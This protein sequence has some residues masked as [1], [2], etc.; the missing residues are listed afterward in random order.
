MRFWVGLIGIAAFFSAGMLHAAPSCLAYRLSELQLL[1][2]LGQGN[3]AEAHLA[4]LVDSG[5]AVFIGDRAI[6]NP[7]SRPKIQAL[8]P[9]DLQSLRQMGLPE[10]VAA[11]DAFKNDV[12]SNLAR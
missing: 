5:E 8:S 4:R 11:V 9:E 1:D 7:T 6:L 3:S 2:K 12:R 10:A